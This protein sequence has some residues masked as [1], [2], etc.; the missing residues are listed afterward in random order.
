MRKIAWVA[1]A[2][3][4]ILVLLLIILPAANPAAP[5]QAP[6]QDGKPSEPFSLGIYA[7]EISDSG[8]G[9]AAVLQMFAT[10]GSDEKVFARCSDRPIADSILILDHP[11]VPGISGSLPQQLAVSVERCGFSYDIVKIEDALTWKD[12]VL[13]A[14]TG[15]LPAGL[16]GKGPEMAERNLR[17]IVVE[18]L[19]GRIIGKNG[20][21]AQAPQGASATRPGERQ[22]APDFESI[23]LSPSQEKGAALQSA[24]AALA[25]KDADEVG[26]GSRGKELSVAVPMKGGQQNAYCRIYQFSNSSCRFSDTGKIVKPNGRLYAKAEALSGENVDFEF[27]L[28]KQ[29]GGR[30]LKLYAVDYAGRKEVGRKEV[31]DG[32]V[33]SGWAGR[34]TL[35]LTGEGRHS[36]W[37]VDQFGRRHASATLDV[38]GFSAS[39]VKQ[40][41]SRL[42]FSTLF[43]GMPL[44]G[45][46]EAWIDNGAK[47]K[48]HSDNGTLAIWASPAPGS[49]IVHLSYRGMEVESKI[50]FGESQFG[51]YLRLLVPA[52]LFLLAVFLLLRSK[53]KVK[54]RI[55]FPHFAHGGRETV[56]A[57][58]GDLVEAWREADRKL[59]GHCLPASCG[60]IGKCLP[61][62]LGMKRG[63]MRGGAPGGKAAG[64]IIGSADE[65]AAFSQSSMR[66]ALLELSA[67]GLFAESDGFFI[68]AKYCGGFSAWENRALRLVHDVLLENGLPFSKKRA[69]AVRGIGLEI[70]IFGGN[71]SVLAGIGRERRIVVFEDA[72]ALSEFRKTLAM[73]TEESVAIKLA[74]QNGKAE[75]VIATRKGIESALR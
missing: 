60:E 45:D 20:T 9:T 23:A 4:A 47:M 31:A 73:P 42:E 67:Q 63:K 69:V 35:R 14:P 64:Q 58:A 57:G 18:S 74:E 8:N 7:A 12:A 11:A 6:A 30:R 56:E 24:Q 22:P 70:A 66:R 2:A 59:G 75:F 72:H 53:D 41:N 39:L 68:P 52:L 5:M 3:A 29:E 37:L 49:R 27:S 1:L 51:N 21:I 71:G 43:G 26:I 40:G 34:F 33:A 32:I 38:R 48:F 16:L 36:V 28:G 25:G 61:H 13:I 17:L 54:Y 15:A 46:V 50:I 55:T 10:G 62:I 19:P 65:E 44:D